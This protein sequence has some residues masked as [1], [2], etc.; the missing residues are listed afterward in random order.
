[1][2]TEQMLRRSPALAALGAVTSAHHEKCNGSGYHKRVCVDAEDV[3]ACVLAATEVYVGMT[4]ERAVRR[5][6]PR[7]PRPNS[8]GSSRKACWSHARPM[9]NR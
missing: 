4:S 3:G 6:P 8:A 5:S 7:V 1:M 9:P 2:L